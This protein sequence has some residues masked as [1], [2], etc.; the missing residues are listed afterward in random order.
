MADFI[1][2]VSFVQNRYNALQHLMNAANAKVNRYAKHSTP[3]EAEAYRQSLYGD[4]HHLVTNKPTVDKHDDAL[5]AMV[6]NTLIDKYR[7]ASPETT[8]FLENYVNSHQD[9]NSPAYKDLLHFKKGDKYLKINAIPESHPFVR[10]AQY[11]SPSHEIELS[12]KLFLPAIPHEVGHGIGSATKIAPPIFTEDY[13]YKMQDDIKANGGD[14]SYLDRDKR[15]KFLDD[16][17]SGKNVKPSEVEWYLDKITGHYPGHPDSK[18]NIANKYGSERYQEEIRASKLGSDHFIGQGM[19]PTTVRDYSYAGLPSY[20]ISSLYNSGIFNAAQLDDIKDKAVAWEKAYNNAGGKNML[21]FPIDKR[22]YR[23]I[24]APAYTREA[25]QAAIEAERQALQNRNSIKPL[26]KR[27]E[28]FENSGYWV[29]GMEPLTFEDRMKEISVY[30][31]DPRN[32]Y[33][34]YG[35]KWAR[36]IWKPKDTLAQLMGYDPRKQRNF[37]DYY[38]MPELGR[39]FTHAKASGDPRQLED[40]S[41]NY[42]GR[43]LY[44]DLNNARDEWHDTYNAFRGM[45][46]DGKLDPIM[47]QHADR[48][49]HP[50]KVPYPVGTPHLN[51]GLKFP[52]Y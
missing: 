36:N 44:L 12:N 13:Y 25:Q 16:L 20:G 34:Q 28:G 19:D 26:G 9:P 4:I 27:P 10:N 2:P 3:E 32:N 37:K 49:A 31:P 47:Q 42:R 24:A 48:L 43:E 33:S 15:Y 52:F 46:E 11:T 5:L 40:V 17:G 50:P 38:R 41:R 23:P 6:S 7:K 51:Q 45:D 22:K 30:G 21:G 39:D 1:S 14:F 29:P 8:K 35:Q 18:F